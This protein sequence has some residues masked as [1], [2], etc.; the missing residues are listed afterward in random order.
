MRQGHLG[1]PGYPYPP[2]YLASC[3][4]GLKIYIPYDI[5]TRSFVSFVTFCPYYFR[6]AIH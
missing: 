2:R 4:Q 5:F 6:F 3:E 1:D